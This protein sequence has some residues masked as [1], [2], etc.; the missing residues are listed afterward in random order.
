MIDL[1]Q[2]RGI[3][4]EHIDMHI[5]AQK[6]AIS[7]GLKKSAVILYGNPMLKVL[8]DHI[9]K[10]SGLNATYFNNRSTAENWLDL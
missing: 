3:S 4:S 5:E 10:Q 7:A 9:F 2:Y 1:T 6:Y 8:V